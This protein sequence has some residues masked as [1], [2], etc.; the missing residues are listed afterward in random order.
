MQF[1]QLGGAAY[2]GE[3]M[4]STERSGAVVRAIPRPLFRMPMPN[5]SPDFLHKIQPTFL[6]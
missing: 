5:A 1:K 6:G 3:M 4:I 2:L